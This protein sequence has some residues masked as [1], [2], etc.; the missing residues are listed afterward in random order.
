VGVAALKELGSNDA[1]MKTKIFEQEQ[2]QRA[3]ELGLGISGPQEI[4]IAAPDEP[5][6]LYADR[7]KAILA[8]G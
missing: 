5:S 8:R 6:R 1:I 2:I 4:D 7:L 3:V